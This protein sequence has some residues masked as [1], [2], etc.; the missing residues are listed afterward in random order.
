[1]LPAALV[2]TGMFEVSKYRFGFYVAMIASRSPLFGALGG[3]LGFMLWIYVCS[4]ILLFGAEFA[5]IYR[6]RRAS[7]GAE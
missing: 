3:I 1:V 6:R 4:S 7:E 2:A 5:S